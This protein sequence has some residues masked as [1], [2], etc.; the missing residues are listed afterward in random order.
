MILINIL[1][2]CN[3]DLSQKWGDYTRVFSL[4][5]ALSKHG[6]KIFMIIIRSEH[7]IPRISSF[8]ENGIDVTEIRPPSFMKFK[9]TRGIGR[10]LNYLS[11]LPTI[12]KISSE[13]IKKNGID[14]VYAYMPGIGSSLPAMRVKS[15]HNIKFILDFAD[16]HVF[17][18]PKKIA[19]SSFEKADKIIAITQYLKD[20]LIRRGIDTKKVFI[21]PNGV[22]LE[23]FNPLKFQ[24]DEIEKLRHSFGAKK[25]IVFSGSLQDLTILIDSAVFVIKET[26][27]VRYVIIGD[28]RDPARSKSAWE[29]KV[30]RK[31]LGEYFVFLGRKPRE[32]IP[33]YLL[34]ADVCVDCFPNEPYYAAAHPIKLLEYGACG[35][36]V[37]ATR[38][39]E[40]EKIVKH[41]EYGFLADPDNPSEFAS[42]VVSLL[43]SDN[44]AIQMGKNFSNYIR[45]NFGW[46]KIAINLEEILEEK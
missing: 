29:E 8:K 17:V 7:K 42:Y 15:K 34:C 46:D 24:L 33:K 36:P 2:F 22:D 12:S 26:K 16:L 38:V 13:I 11:C 19:Q 9:G 20:D 35:K 45:T 1:V 23:L 25:L 14:Y 5:N 3:V 31:G 6:H 40:T 32:D 18:R 41:G 21:I 27:D 30:N 39:S 37:V 44:D 4:M 28:H 43:K 10:Y